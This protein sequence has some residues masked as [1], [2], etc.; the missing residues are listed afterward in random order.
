M[1]DLKK[2][3]FP[4]IGDVPVDQIETAQIIEIT[5]RPHIRYGTKTEKPLW[6]SVPERAQRCIKKVEMILR[7][8]ISSGHRG[9][10]NPAQWKDHLAAILPKPEKVRQ[11]ANQPSLPFT[12]LPSFIAALRARKPS[13]TSRA[14]EFLILT[15]ARSGEVRGATWSE[16]DLERGLWTIPAARMKASKDHRVPLSEAALAILNGS[17]RFAGMDLIWPGSGLKKPMSDATLAALLKKMHAADLK[18]GGDG[19]VDPASGRPA[20]PHGFRSTFRVWASEQTSHPYEMVE[21]ALAH[22]VG[23]AV[24]RAYNRTDMVEKR[25]ALMDEWANFALSE[26]PADCST[27]RLIC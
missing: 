19:L 22:N 13:P 6:Q 24:E 26:L 14:L 15:A 11:K 21:M 18:A 27:G 23:T 8:E 10:P 5:E 4:V 12:R 2:F 1:N 16:I 25:R 17:P 7:R 20:T 9:G 3:A